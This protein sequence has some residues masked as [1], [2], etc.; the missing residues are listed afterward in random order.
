MSVL[1]MMA[2]HGAHP[3][4]RRAVQAVQAQT[5][6]DWRLVIVNDADPVPPWD[7]LAGLLDDSRIVTIDL[8]VNGGRYFADAVVLEAFRPTYWALQDPDDW[9]DPERLARM[10]PLAE[11]YG[12]A[13]APTCLHRTNQA[14]HPET[15]DRT[16]LHL[17]PQPDRIRHMVG[18]GSGVI[19]AD[20]IRQ[21]GGFHA[22]VRVGY[23]TYLMNAVRL[24]GPWVAID[25]P[26]LQH[27]YLR[28][29]SLRTSPATG[30]R[31]PYRMRV[32]DRLDRLWRSAWSLHAEG[33]P[34]AHLIEDDVGP[35]LLDEVSATA[36][37]YT[38]VPA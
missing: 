16:G 36:R 25:E 29:G 4:I 17:S 20:R 15:P 1:V 8:P 34:I 32:R 35:G 3:Y 9:P 33:R 7:A 38:E 10:M 23:D 2:F 37:R 27:K 6:R 5:Y 30:D 22:G 18:Y 21:A 11:E 24:T 19:S 14:A 13:F 31:S 26:A 12:A 28:P